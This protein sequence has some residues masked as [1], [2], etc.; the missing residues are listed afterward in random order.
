MIEGAAT[1]IKG[2]WNILDREGGQWKS[3]GA[4]P[5]EVHI[6]EE[7]QQPREIR[8]DIQTLLADI[9]RRVGH[10]EDTAIKARVHRSLVARH[11]RD[12][13]SLLDRIDR[14]KPFRGSFRL[15]TGMSEPPLVRRRAARDIQDVQI[16]DFSVPNRFNEVTLDLFG[17]ALEKPLN[18]YPLFDVL[19]H[20]KVRYGEREGVIE[21]VPEA[22]EEVLS[23]GS[24]NLTVEG[25][26]DIKVLQGGTTLSASARYKFQRFYRLGQEEHLFLVNVSMGF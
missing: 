19:L 13:L 20:G 7:G 26:D 1:T 4:S 16:T 15:V 2:L 17:A 14:G 11:E 24:H 5:Y 21:F 12:G 18:L 25:P 8:A 9:I 10:P 22:T 6:A 3:V 23:M